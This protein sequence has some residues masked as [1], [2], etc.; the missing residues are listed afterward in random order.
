VLLPSLG[1]RLR[2]ALTVALV[3]LLVVGALGVT[4]YTAS[5]NLEDALMQQL[6]DGEMDYL[7]ERH[8]Q[9]PG[10]VP[11]PA[12]NFQNY[13]VRGPEDRERLPAHMREL[14]VGYHEAFVGEEE[15]EVLVREANGVRYYIAYEVGLYEQRE[16]SF[17]ILVWITVLAAAFV[18]LALGYW[19]SGVLVSQVTGLAREVSDL[20]PGRPRG[21][22]ARP[23]QVPEVAL[24][25]RA[26]DDYQARIEQMIRR[27]QEFTA[28]ASHELRT[29]LTA[30]K[31]SSELLLADPKLS[32]KSRAR[33]VQVNEAAA[34]MAEQI[35]ALLF[36]ARGKALGEVEPVV[37]ADCIAEAVEPCRAEI[38]RKGLAFEMAVVPDAVL[39]LN[40]QAL[41][42]VLT[43]LIRNAVNY[44]DRGFVKVG[45][46][47]RRLTVAD[48][49]RGMNPE[50][51]PRV[52][53]R[54]F[55][56]EYAAGS[57]GLGLSIV[58]SVCDHYGWG[59]TVDSAP[60]MGSTF[61]ITLL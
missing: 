57:M 53:E 48:S 34:R 23:D 20:K 8:R 36:L 60:A 37:L 40:Y 16:Q 32:D 52:F 22:L 29:P 49:G 50:H 61:S 1:L 21:A 24:L 2:I 38:E 15:F 58:K 54:F 51:L 17:K 10:F 33:V 12:A 25:A 4:L 3:C 9:D 43:N 35:Q 5:E 26:F 18:S 27:E 13:I 59:I 41:R 45:Y 47:S 28:N 6:V 19:L 14:G 11:Q 42:F 44:T 31:T 7:V 30:I 46:A 39:D 56:N 55:R